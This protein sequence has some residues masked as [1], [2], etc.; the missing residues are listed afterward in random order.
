MA[1]GFDETGA[2]GSSHRGL[3]ELFSYPLMAAIFDRRTRRVARGTSITSG[4]ISHTS[5]NAPAPLSPLEEAVLVVSTGLTGRV[6]MHDVPA[7]KPDG[8]G[9]FAAP[10]I[11]I[12]ARSASSIDNAHAV[13]FFLIND[14][15]TWLIRHFRNK[16]ALALLSQL[17]PRW[18]DWTEGDWLAAA[19]AVK[20]RLY[21]ERLDFPR[22]WP[23]FFIWNRQLSNRPGTTILLPIVDLTR[24][25]INVLLSLLSEEDG[26]RPLFIDDWRGFHPKTLLD[27][28]AWFSS[29][30]GLLP[31]I[32]YHSGSPTRCGPTTRHSSNCRT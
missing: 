17:P 22:H 1:A 7:R 3:Q 18:E 27:W 6:T 29:L 23:Y 28:G 12:L 4:P 30:V 2:P 24:Q 25:L 26:Q 13:S 14:E 32:S 21:K 10:L 16:D 20:H 11:N 19:A 5:T 15:G 31:K 9:Q 8:T